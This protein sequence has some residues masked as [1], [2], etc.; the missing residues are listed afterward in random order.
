MIWQSVAGGL[1]A[2]LVKISSYV[3]IQYFVSCLIDLSA[4]WLQLQNLIE[5]GEVL[6]FTKP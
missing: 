5:N 2:H 3:Y 4:I 6:L 1:A